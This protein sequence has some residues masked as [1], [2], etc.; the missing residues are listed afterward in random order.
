MEKYG[1]LA[2]AAEAEVAPFVCNAP[3]LPRDVLMIAD[4]VRVVGVEGLLA[5]MALVFLVEVVGEPSVPMQ[6]IIVVIEVHCL[7]L[8]A[9]Q[10]S[11]QS[12]HTIL[13]HPRLIP[14]VE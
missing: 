11:D 3:V 9:P 13:P 7:L 14:D 8:E 12:L 1:D 5:D 6:P 10:L 2:G 4:L